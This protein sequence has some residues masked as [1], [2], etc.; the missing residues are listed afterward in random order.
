[1]IHQSEPQ[2]RQLYVELNPG[3]RVEVEHEVKVGL[4]VWTVT[5]VGT[6]VEKHRRRHSLHFKRNVDDKVWSDVL[7]LRRDDGEL[8]TV[9]IDEFTRIVRHDHAPA[10]HPA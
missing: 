2:M 3:D 8:T 9:T 10:S 5:T 1:M 6:V 4:K 7:I